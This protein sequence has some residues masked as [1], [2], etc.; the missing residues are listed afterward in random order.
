MSVCKPWRWPY[1]PSSRRPLDHIWAR[2]RWSCSE[3]MESAGLG[4]RVTA[5]L[6]PCALGDSS[7]VWHSWH[8]LV[9]H[10]RHLHHQ[11]NMRVNEAGVW[12]GGQSR[13]WVSSVDVQS[14]FR[15]DL[16]ELWVLKDRRKSNSKANSR[17]NPRSP[18]LVPEAAFSCG[19]THSWHQWWRLL[20][21]NVIKS[22]LTSHYQ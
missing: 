14:Q 17:F 19:W 15:P 8:Q 6:R 16:R 11:E 4:R 2:P 18:C 3:C 10:A 20:W 9:I 22:W 1:A 12:W 13:C 7:C 5:V 21:L